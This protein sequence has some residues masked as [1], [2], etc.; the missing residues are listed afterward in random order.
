MSR[1]P[2]LRGSAA[3]ALGLLGLALLVAFVSDAGE[4]PV[5]LF[6]WNSYST[7]AI[8]ATHKVYDHGILRARAVA[9]HSDDYR[10]GPIVVKRTLHNPVADSRGYPYPTND[11]TGHG[12]PQWPS[13]A[14]I[15]DT[16][17][18]NDHPVWDGTQL[19]RNW[20]VPRDGVVVSKNCMFLPRK[21]C[22][23]ETIKAWRHGNLLPHKDEQFVMEEDSKWQG[24]DQEKPTPGEKEARKFFDEQKQ[25]T[26]S[27][28]VG[29]IQTQNRLNAPALSLPAVPTTAT[30]GGFPF[31]VPRGAPTAVEYEPLGQRQGW[32][33]GQ[34][35]LSAPGLGR[36]AM[37]PMVGHTIP[38]SIMKAFARDGGA[39][40]LKKK[41][42]CHTCEVAVQ[43]Q[44]VVR[45]QQPIFG[46]PV[47][48]SAGGSAAP[49]A[50][51]APPLPQ[52]L[53]PP[54]AVAAP[55]GVTPDDIMTGKS[56]PGYRRYWG[57][58]GL[59]MD[60]AGLSGVE[61][62]LPPGPG[63]VVVPGAGATG[64]GG[65]FPP[66]TAWGQGTAIHAASSLTPTRAIRTTVMSPPRVTPGSGRPTVHVDTW[67][68]GHPRGPTWLTGV[69]P[70]AQVVPPARSTRVVGQGQGL[71]EGLHGLKA[72]SVVDPSIAT[73]SG[74]ETAAVDW[75]LDAALGQADAPGQQTILATPRARKQ[76]A[77]ARMELR[78]GVVPSD[79]EATTYRSLLADWWPN[80]PLV[81]PLSG[82]QRVP[83]EAGVESAA[84]AAAS[85]EHLAPD[86]WGARGED[87]AVPAPR[88]APVPRREDKVVGLGRAS[89]SEMGKE[90]VRAL[91]SMVEQRVEAD[92]SR[93]RPAQEAQQLS[94]LKS[95]GRA[96]ALARRKTSPGHGLDGARGGLSDRLQRQRLV[97]GAMR[98]E[99]ALG[100]DMDTVR[101]ELEVAGLPH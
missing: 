65:P 84:Q 56:W 11:A 98:L 71:L 92:E 21:D 19:Y 100:H 74:S 58:I 96:E 15:H 95:G 6:S 97:A 55:L 23:P 99:K 69:V 75:N 68:P 79:A 91:A 13:N 42:K 57:G 94:E 85:E 89:G 29:A 72:F 41:V 33:Y 53:A 81:T 35:P 51:S 8:R 60:A 7:H 5:A 28:H 31:Y 82:T 36:A 101:S 3:L 64:D 24:P 26:I 18:G 80:V 78:A 14:P 39:P 83:G 63:S 50:A 30:Y 47:S 37:V 49:A 52:S 27:R 44:P 34:T 93:M 9:L 43:T 59:R 62:P 16:R 67:S 46:V 10:M 12:T 77:L 61:A 48:P 45:V 40:P 20:G 90:L 2:P 1:P 88:P 25:G 54:A 4:L 73:Q 66:F 86:T 70:P 17:S 76:S 38:D 22:L 32:N 87:V